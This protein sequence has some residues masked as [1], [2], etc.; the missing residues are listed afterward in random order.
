MH[1]FLKNPLAQGVQMAFM[2]LR[3]EVNAAA[4]FSMHDN[5]RDKFGFL[6][7][8]H[9]IRTNDQFI[10]KSRLG[11]HVFQKFFQ[12]TVKIQRPMSR[13]FKVIKKESS[14]S[15]YSY[16]LLQHIDSNV[17]LEGIIRLFRGLYQLILA[18]LFCNS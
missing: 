9:G 7:G 12:H 2:A 17:S 11:P 1:G 15:F 8:W 16:F 4:I 13:A 3:P 18:S 10:L 14:L 5:C 6:P